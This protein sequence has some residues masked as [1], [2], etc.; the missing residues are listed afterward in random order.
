MAEMSGRVIPVMF[1]T[2]L[3]AVGNMRSVNL[4]EDSYMAEL[5]LLITLG[6]S[7]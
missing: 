5:N 3:F 2:L 6:L 4:I 7:K 1:Q